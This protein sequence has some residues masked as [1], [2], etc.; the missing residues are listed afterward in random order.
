MIT[1]PPPPPLGANLRRL[2]AQ[3]GLTLSETAAVAQLD[4]RTV[5]N[6]LRERAQPQ[7]RT[8]HKLAGGLGVSVDEFFQ[9]VSW[10]AGAGAAAL[11]RA[12]NPVAAEVIAAHPERFA[13]WSAAEFDE[14]YSRVGVGGELTESGALAAAEGINRR[15]QLMTQVAVV[16]ETDQGELLQE[17]VELLYRRVT[18]AATSS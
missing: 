13:Q 11:D 7:S 16:L 14:L 1:R 6:I 8:L 18:T 4:V 17:L 9:S 10:G 5:R 12:C 15:R 2:M 3:L